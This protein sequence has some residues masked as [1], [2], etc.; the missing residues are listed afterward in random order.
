MAKN[1][2]L[3]NEIGAV[4]DFYTGGIAKPFP[5]TGLTKDIFTHQMSDHLP[6]WC[7]LNTDNGLIKLNQIINRDRAC[8]IWGLDKALVRQR[9][10]SGTQADTKQVSRDI[11]P[12]VD[13]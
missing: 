13:S 3:F 5:G 2:E 1:A 12:V 7:Q 11:V 8:W 10:A 9:F 6:L 4:L